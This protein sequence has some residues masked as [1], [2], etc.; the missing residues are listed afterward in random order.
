M[1]IDR[2]LVP[3]AGMN[4]QGWACPTSHPCSN[5]HDTTA[6]TMGIEPATLRFTMEYPNEY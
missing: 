2:L 1:G 5:V 6:R 3:A 4:A